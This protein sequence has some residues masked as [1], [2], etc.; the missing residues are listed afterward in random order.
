MDLLHL[1]VL[2]KKCIEKAKELKIDLEFFQSNIEG[3]IVN[4]I[5]EARKNFDGMIINAAG[6][7]YISCNQRCS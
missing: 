1:I 6:Y 4:K 5:Q 2:K 3:E 7:T